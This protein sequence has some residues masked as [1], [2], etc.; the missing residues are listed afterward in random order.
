M[1]FL[2]DGRSLNDDFDC[3]TDAAYDEHFDPFRIAPIDPAD[4][5]R[6]ILLL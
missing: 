1:L 3:T 4:R 6:N 5:I 2:G